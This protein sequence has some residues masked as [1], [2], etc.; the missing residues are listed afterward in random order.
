MNYHDIKFNYKR[1][2]RWLNV[3]WMCR[4]H[5]ITHSYEST[6]WKSASRLIHHQIWQNCWA[7]KVRSSECINYIVISNSC[8]EYFLNL[9]DTDECSTGS[10]CGD[11]A[12][13]HT[14]CQNT[15]G[16]FACVCVEGFALDNVTELCEGESL[17]NS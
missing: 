16:G 10:P 11:P 9:K 1:Y 3:A 7:W 13:N 2:L 8:D 6:E 12:V 5:Q 17:C 15:E 14:S 4:R